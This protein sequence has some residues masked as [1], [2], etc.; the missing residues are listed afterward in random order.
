[1][2]QF[3]HVKPNRPENEVCHC[4]GGKLHPWLEYAK[5]YAKAHG[6]TYLEALD[7]AE[8]SFRSIVTRYGGN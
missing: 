5:E 4:K 6:L 3:K 2:K 1:M 8:P 7:I